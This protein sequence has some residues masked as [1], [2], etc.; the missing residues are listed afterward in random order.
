MV[1][2]IHTCAVEIAPGPVISV[3][4]LFCRAAVTFNLVE[5]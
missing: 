3:R 1:G 2:D 4:L 5:M